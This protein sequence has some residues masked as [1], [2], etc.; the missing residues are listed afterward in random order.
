MN[1]CKIIT[2]ANRKGGVGKTTTTINLGHALQLE[3]YKVLLVDFDSQANLSK[4]LG[5]M[6]DETEQSICELLLPIVRGCEEQDIHNF[7]NIHKTGL[8]YIPAKKT[9]SALELEMVGTMQREYIL[10]NRT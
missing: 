8:H 9:L 10:K 6:P 1:K 5:C 2:I 3:G 4:G 7:I